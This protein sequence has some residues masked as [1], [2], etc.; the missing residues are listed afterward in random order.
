M[1]SS[2]V[3][4]FA[5]IA[6][7]FPAPASAETLRVPKQFATP[8]L[9]TTAA[10]DGDLILVSPGTYTGTVN[11]NGK[12]GVTIRGT[13]RDEVV[14]RY[15]EAFT[16]FSAI[17]VFNCANLRIE[18]LTIDGKADRAIRCQLVDGVTVSNVRVVQTGAAPLGP[19]EMVACT[20]VRV[21]RVEFRGLGG[22]ALILGESMSALSG[23]LEV[24]RCRFVDIGGDAI[25][26]YASE[27][28]VENNR[29]TNV[30]GN[31]IALLEG[32]FIG[33]AHIRKNRFVDCKLVG[34]QVKNL[35][36][37]VTIEGNRFVG[38]TT[39]AVWVNQARSAIVRK[40]RLI[41][42]LAIGI[43]V[44]PNDSL[45][46]G[47][48]IERSGNV[49]I[50][51]N[52]QRT[53]VARNAVL[54]CKSLAIETYSPRVVFEDNVIRSPLDIGILVQGGCDECRLDGNRISSPSNNGID[55]RS[56]G[57]SFDGNVVRGSQAVG[58]DLAGI[59]HTLKRNSCHGS[60]GADLH[61]DLEANTI[62]ASNRFGTIEDIP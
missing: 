14:L 54:D 25:T 40:N 36:T 49:G 28:R 50:L 24:S 7:A 43:E 35:Q 26:I 18:N 32:F 52:G 61:C 10:K 6:P 56:D 1:R 37:V 11:L 13:D 21:E 44:D 12:V 59:G 23:R 53:V 34:I 2:L 27:V 41:D 4:A 9:A 62:A 47:N 48:E 60:T 22:A 29:F 17:Q 15:Q 19:I 38:G 39:Y 46:E 3:L 31:A 57:C 30:S 8:A 45:V 42:V 33:D 55:V 16:I 51:A 58:F 5:L 20:G